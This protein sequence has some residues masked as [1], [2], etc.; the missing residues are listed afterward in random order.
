MALILILVVKNNI[1]WEEFVSFLECKNG[2]PG[3]GL[4]Q[5]VNAILGSIV[6]DLLHCHRQRFNGAGAAAGK[7]KELQV[8]VYRLNPKALHTYYANH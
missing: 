7:D 1:N 4:Y 2:L 5:T 6:L 3:A 8:Q